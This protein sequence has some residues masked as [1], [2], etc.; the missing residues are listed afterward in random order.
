MDSP[1]KVLEGLVAYLN[2][3]G[4]AGCVER[5]LEAPDALRALAAAT[6]RLCEAEGSERREHFLGARRGSTRVEGHTHTHSS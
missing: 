2:N 1:F 3:G 6:G 4:D 5:F